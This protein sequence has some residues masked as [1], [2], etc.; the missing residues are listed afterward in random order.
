[1]EREVLDVKR[2]V[3]GPEHPDT[4]TTM[5]NLACSLGG[6]GKLALAAEG[7]SKIGHRGEPIIVLRR[8]VAHAHPPLVRKPAS[9]RSRKVLLA[10][11][12]LPPSSVA[13]VCRVR[14]RRLDEA[15][16]VLAPHR[17]GRR[18]PS[19][20]EAGSSRGKRSTL[21]RAPFRESVSS[22]EFWTEEPNLTNLIPK[23][24]KPV[25]P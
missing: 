4:P 2:R 22:R 3:L 8:L 5:G 13:S 25:I 7:D 16:D 24:V 20:L 11:A 12:T 17:P 23:N 9:H 1:M 10:R 15:A 18:S 6:Q 14:F 21:R 19:G